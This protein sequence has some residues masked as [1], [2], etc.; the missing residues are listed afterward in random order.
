MNSKIALTSIHATTAALLIAVAAPQAQAASLGSVS[1]VSTIN[2]PITVDTT[3][4]NIV[5]WG[6]MV[7]TNDSVI[8]N[9]HTNKVFNTL[10]GTNFA[11][12]GGD[13]LVTTTGITTATATGF[14]D[15]KF[16]FDDGNS[17]ATG[18]GVAAGDAFAGWASNEA[19]SLVFT[20][21]DIGIGT[22]TF[23]LFV[24]HR[25]NTNNDTNAR[26][27]KMNYS[28]TASDGN[29]AGN[30][31]SNAFNAV[32]VPSLARVN[33]V[34]QITIVNNVDAGA[35][36]VLGW[37]SVSGG[38]G[39]G[40]FSGYTVESVVPEPSSLALMGLGGLLIARRR[41]AKS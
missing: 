15:F 10:S 24:G 22:H 30:I 31:N 1:F 38:T 27:F 25:L 32:D 41:R 29:V 17:P 4:A 21:N 2:T 18:T 11:S 7:D 16:T 39:Q 33:S 26:V 13:M 23:S 37:D 12:G 35:D 9:N 28:L 5:D 20:F 8:Y 19:G 36:L 40:V 34:F 3:G 6:F 14:G